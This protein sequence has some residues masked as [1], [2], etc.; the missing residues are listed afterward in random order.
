MGHSTPV[1]DPENISAM[2]L[3]LTVVTLFTALACVFAEPEADAWHA[4]YY[5]YPSTY[6]YS[7]Y[8]GYPYGY[9]GTFREYPIPRAK[10]SAEAWDPFYCYNCRWGGWRSTNYGGY[11][12]GGYYNYGKRHFCLQ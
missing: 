2:N 9:Y 8:Y 1:S 7:G 10:R 3:L 5:G 6:G 4:Y 12:S 11:H